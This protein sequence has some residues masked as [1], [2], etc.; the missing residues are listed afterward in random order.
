MKEENYSCAL[1]CYTKAIHLDQRNA[2][3]FCNRWG[4]NSNTHTHTSKPW[5]C[6]ATKPF[7]ARLKVLPLIWV[8]DRRHTLHTGCSSDH[9]INETGNDLRSACTVQTASLHWNL[10]VESKK[11]RDENVVYVSGLQHTA[12]W[13]TTRKRSETVS[14]PSLSIPRTVKR[15]DAWGEELTFIYILL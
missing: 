3:Y 15:T 5:L 14:A 9:E 11:G 10:N 6:T 13:E 7:L 1:D 2:V 8:K 4:H 12:N